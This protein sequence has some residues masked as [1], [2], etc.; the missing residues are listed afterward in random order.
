MNTIKGGGVTPLPLQ[1]T[2]RL[3][4]AEE[5]KL[6]LLKTEIEL[7][8]HTGGGHNAVKDNKVSRSLPAIGMK[9]T[10]KRR[11]SVFDSMV[12]KERLY[13]AKMD[14]PGRKSPVP[15][16]VQLIREWTET[17]P[18]DFRDEKMMRA[19]KDITQICA[20]LSPVDILRTCDNPLILAQQLTHIE[21]ERLNNIGP[22]EFVQTFIKSPA[23]SGE[24]KKTSNIE[25]YV[26]WFN[27]LSYL[28]ATEI[29]VSDRERNRV[30]LLEFFVDTAIQCL[31]LNNFN[32]FMAI[33]AGLYM[34]PVVRLK[35][36]RAKLSS[37]KFE[38][39]EV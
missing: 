24:V 31:G 27:R 2:E 19:L 35:K 26:E 33:A 20:T 1:V 39:L 10:P 13:A 16:F 6:R 15:H 25:A 23:D 22:E 3:L 28:V 7:A 34:S 5:Q 11:P 4:E 9:Q 18:Y 17:F 30:R 12:P 8:K 29:C 32:S 37:D 14:E 38:E 21:L 36:T